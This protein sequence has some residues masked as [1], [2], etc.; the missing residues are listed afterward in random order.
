MLYT[1]KVHNLKL[2]KQEEDELSHLFKRIDR[3]NDG[4][5]DVTDLAAAFTEMKVPQMPGQAQVMRYDDYSL[6]KCNVIQ[7]FY[8]LVVKPKVKL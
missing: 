3:N 5:I 1:N 7:I 2:T 4:K 6:K 8:C